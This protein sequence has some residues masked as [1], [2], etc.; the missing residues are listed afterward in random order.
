MGFNEGLPE[1]TRAALGNVRGITEI[2]MFGGLCFTV[3]GNMAWAS[4]LHEPLG[5][6][7][8]SLTC[9][10]YY[11]HNLWVL[12]KKG[13]KPCGQGSSE[14]TPRPSNSPTHERTHSLTE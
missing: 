5:G 3:H 14:N 10:G 7:K 4:R 12:G 1:R 6:R 8:G 9:C 11:S 2:R 13:R